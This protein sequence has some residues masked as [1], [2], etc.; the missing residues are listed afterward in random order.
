M[1]D[2]HRY[3][4][5]APP[6]HPRSREIMHRVHSPVRRSSPNSVFP[7][8]LFSR[9]PQNPQN[10][11][12][13]A[14]RVYV[15]RSNQR[16]SDRWPDRVWCSTFVGRPHR[17]HP[18][19]AQIVSPCALALT[20]VVVVVVVFGDEDRVD[21]GA[22]G[23]IAAKVYA[24]FSTLICLSRSQLARLLDRAL[25]LGFVLLSAHDVISPFTEP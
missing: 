10:L 19:H 7:V 13:Q 22:E 25:G 3:R 23:L 24:C 17:P 9:D 16:W 8:T 12:T 6:R 1:C 20:V 15:H 14:R 21:S 4:V 2:D 5:C 11:S 18:R